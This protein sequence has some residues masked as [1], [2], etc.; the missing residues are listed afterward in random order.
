[1]KNS[2]MKYGAWL[3]EWAESLEAQTIKLVDWDR[4]RI[5][6]EMVATYRLGE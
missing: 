6:G 4:E 1:M 3:S 5:L 2:R